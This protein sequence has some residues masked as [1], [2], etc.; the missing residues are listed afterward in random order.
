MDLRFDDCF[1]SP[2]IAF[3]DE[4]AVELIQDVNNDQFLSDRG[5]TKDPDRF[6]WY[7]R[8]RP[9]PATVFSTI[10]NERIAKPYLDALRTT[11]DAR[12]LTF[13]PLLEN[14][15]PV[16]TGGDLPALDLL[17][18]VVQQRQGNKELLLSPPVL[19]GFRPTKVRRFDSLRT[20]C[21]RASSP[22]TAKPYGAG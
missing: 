9:V 3:K 14:I 18:D 7:M 15:G 20:R 5:G 8:L 16:Q 11:D 12:D 21:S 13:V 6:C 2:G 1:Q 10:W 4:I 22:M 19:I 17:F